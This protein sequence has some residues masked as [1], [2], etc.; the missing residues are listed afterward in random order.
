MTKFSVH[1]IHSQSDRANGPARCQTCCHAHEDLKLGCQAH[2]FVCR[3]AGNQSIVM[4]HGT[5]INLR[6]AMCMLVHSSPSQLTLASCL[7]LPLGYNSFSRCCTPLTEEV[8]QIDLTCMCSP[9]LATYCWQICRC[10]SHAQENFCHLQGKIG[11]SNP[12]EY[13]ETCI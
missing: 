10:I 11:F 5:N 12:D 1:R 9:L 4:E 13:E 8:C 6:C 2:A 7:I 3:Q